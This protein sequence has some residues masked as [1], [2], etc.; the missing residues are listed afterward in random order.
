MTTRRVR[1][2]FEKPQLN[3][4]DMENTCPLITE[5]LASANVDELALRHNE[6]SLR[7]CTRPRVT[8]YPVVLMPLRSVRLLLPAIVFRTLSK[9]FSVRSPKDIPI[10]FGFIVCI[11]NVDIFLILKV[12]IK[13]LY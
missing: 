4:L 8:S 13:F 7:A 5:V 9:T 2:T 6:G 12:Y 3:P 1:H 11:S 10:S